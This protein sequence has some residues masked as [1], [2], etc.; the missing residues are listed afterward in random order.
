VDV[1]DEEGEDDED[2]VDEEEVLSTADANM[3]KSS[4]NDEFVVINLLLR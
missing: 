3:A 4:F 2:E 1:D